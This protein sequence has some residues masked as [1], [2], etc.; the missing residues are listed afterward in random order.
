MLA[1]QQI[2]IDTESQDILDIL[3]NTRLSENFMALA[4][5]LDVVE[6]KTPEDIYKSHL[7]NTR[8]LVESKFEI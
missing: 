5:D 4:R 7:E 6:A 2:R 8:E 1:R 3:N